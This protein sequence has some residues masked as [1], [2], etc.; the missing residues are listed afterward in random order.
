MNTELNVPNLT[1]LLYVATHN[2]S[3]TVKH[4]KLNHMKRNNNNNNNIDVKNSI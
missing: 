1:R 4:G 2:Y 3:H